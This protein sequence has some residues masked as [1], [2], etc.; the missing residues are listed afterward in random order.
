MAK[1]NGLRGFGNPKKPAAPKE[2]P[3]PRNHDAESQLCIA[4]RNGVLVSFTYDGERRYYAPYVVYYTST[5]KVCAFGMQ[6]GNLLAPS[7]RTDPHNFEVGKIRSI[8]LTTYEFQT[9]PSFDLSQA[10]YRRRICPL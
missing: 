3:A 8:Q 1:S 10:R 7:D 5:G 6:V 9:D 4:I 2:P